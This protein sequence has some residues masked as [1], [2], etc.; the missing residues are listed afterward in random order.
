MFSCYI[1]I[2]KLSKLKTE[3]ERFLWLKFYI[4][5]QYSWGIKQRIDKD[6]NE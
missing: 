4:N 2:L 1:F 6:K 5:L 3:Y